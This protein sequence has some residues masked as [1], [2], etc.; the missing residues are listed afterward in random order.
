M[1]ISKKLE[2]CMF[3]SISLGSFSEKVGKHYDF[4]HIFINKY[5]NIWFFQFVFQKMFENTMI[6]IQLV[7]TLYF[8][9]FYIESV[10]K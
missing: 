2:N 8:F 9:N 1:S 10:S 6:L 3:L 7:S 4:D 5:E